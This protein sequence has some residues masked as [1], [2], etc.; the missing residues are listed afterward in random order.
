MASKLELPSCD[1]VGKGMSEVLEATAQHVRT[2][3][4]D[5]KRLMKTLPLDPL[6]TD[7]GY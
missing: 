1:P 5:I 6:H 2:P 4:Q 3:K 7:N